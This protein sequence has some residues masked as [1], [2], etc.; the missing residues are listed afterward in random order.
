MAMADGHPF[1]RPMLS[2]M[3]AMEVYIRRPELRLYARPVAGE[4]LAGRADAAKRSLA[5]TVR[6]Y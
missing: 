6:I 5:I 3:R 1:S 4:D 2:L